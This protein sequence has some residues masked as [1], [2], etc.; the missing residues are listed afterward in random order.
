MTPTE[1]SSKTPINFKQRL[2]VL[3]YTVN[4][5]FSICYCCC[6]AQPQP[7]SCIQHLNQLLSGWA[8]TVLKSQEESSIYHKKQQRNQLKCLETEPNALKLERRIQKLIITAVDHRGFF[9]SLSQSQDR[10][11]VFLNIV[12]RLSPGT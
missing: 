3:S 4:K 2:D 8:H 5:I 9:T 1:V 7:N 12:S 10:T 11:N 6:D